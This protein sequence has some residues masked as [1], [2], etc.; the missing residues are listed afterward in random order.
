MKYR[1][2]IT[3]VD[4]VLTNGCFTY[5]E[6]GKIYKQFGPHDSDGF[7]ILNKEGISSIGI[8]ADKRGFEISKKR[9]DDLEIKLHLVKE[10]DR[11]NWLLKNVVPEETI[12]IGDGL[13]DIPC[14][15][16]CKISYAP[17]NALD[18]TKKFASHVTNSSGGEGVIL[19]V[20][21]S[22]LKDVNPEKYEKI[23]KGIFI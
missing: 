12:F 11:L 15:K 4:G 22:I 19:E 17:K 10:E 7:K 2:L 9:F 1:K 18:L 14:M 3:D 8:T 21:L 16:I 6:Q 13:Y 23:S 5:S 20:A